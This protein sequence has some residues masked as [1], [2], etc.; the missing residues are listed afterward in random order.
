[1]YGHFWLWKHIPFGGFCWLSQT[2]RSAQ[3][4]ASCLKLQ[5]NKGH[6]SVLKTISL[7][8]LQSGIL[9]NRATQ[10]FLSHLFG[11]NRAPSTVPGQCKNNF[12]LLKESIWE[13]LLLLPP[14]G[15]ALLLL[16]SL[17][18]SLHYFCLQKL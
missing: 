11:R 18:A 14:S 4:T 15:I 7:P 3:S 17:Q 1:M 12:S 6:H 5:V 13:N 10:L 2:D 16:L 9:H 8:H